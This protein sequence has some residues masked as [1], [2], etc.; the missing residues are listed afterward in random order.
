MSN[1]TPATAS[2][3]VAVPLGTVLVVLLWVAKVQNLW[4]LGD[5]SW[6]IVFAPYWL[7][8]L[9]FFGILGIIAAFVGVAFL[10]TTALDWNKKRKREKRRAALEQQLKDGN[11]TP[12]EFS[13][14]NGLKFKTMVQ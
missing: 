1:N 11:I 3:S 6:W 7:P 8:L 13:R 4:G 14:Q 10:V 2:A 9:V 12:N 5:I